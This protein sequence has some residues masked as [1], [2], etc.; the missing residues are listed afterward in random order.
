[1]QTKISHIPLVLLSAVVFVKATTSAAEARSPRGWVNHHLG[2]I[3]KEI[4]HAEKS[5]VSG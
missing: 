2:G 4:T 3:E 5:L 1:M